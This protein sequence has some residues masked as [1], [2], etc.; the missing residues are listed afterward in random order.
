MPNIFVLLLIIELFAKT[1]INSWAQFIS[2]ASH[3]IPQPTFNTLFMPTFYNSSLF[4]LPH[5]LFQSVNV[6][7]NPLTCL[8]YLLKTQNLECVPSQVKQEWQSSEGLNGNLRQKYE[9]NEEFS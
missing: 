7:L 6:E 4:T 2:I 5:N 3:C 9:E 1:S 8:H